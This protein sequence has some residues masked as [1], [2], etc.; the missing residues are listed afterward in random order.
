MRRK[1][2][3]AVAM[4]VAGGAA[5]LVWQRQVD[6]PSLDPGRRRIAEARVTGVEYGA[7]GGRGARGDQ[8]ASRS[9]HAELEER[10]RTAP[11]AKNLHRLAL[12]NFALLRPRAAEELLTRAVSL[13][14]GDAP[15]LSDLAAAEMELGQVADAAE[16]AARALELDPSYRPAAFNWALALDKFSNRP[17][18][19]EAWERY[20]ELDPA[21]PWAV[22]ARQHLQRLDGPRPE[23]ERDKLLL[24]AGS[25][26]D[27]VDRIARAYPQRTRE[28]ALNDLLP[29]FVDSGNA[30]ALAVLRK[31]AAIRTEAGDSFLHDAVEHAVANRESVAD[32]F[33]AFKEGD[34][35]DDANQMDKS[36]P[37]YRKAAESL[38]QAGSPV[39]LAAELYAASAETYAP[40]GGERAL[41]RLDALDQ[42]L[43]SGGSRYPWVKAEVAWIRGFIHV[44]AGRP[45]ECLA[46]YTA[47]LTEARRIGEIE[48]EASLLA[49]IATQLETVGDPFEAEQFRRDA[50]RRLD[51]SNA[52]SRRTYGA[53]LETGT[54]SLRAARPR[55]ALAFLDAAARIGHETRDPMY[56]ADADLWRALA[57]LDIG[58][59]DDA[60]L[61]IASARAQVPLIKDANLATRTS[62]NLE[63]I[64]ARIEAK[65][66]PAL[67]IQA[68]SGAVR[69]W[70]RFGW[71]THLAS[72]YVSR[73]EVYLALQD[74]G[75]AERDFR[76][77][78]EE[79]E[80][81]RETI[82]EPPMRVSY[83]ERADRVFD[84]LIELLLDDGRIEEAFTIAEK[85]RARAL[86]DRIASDGRAVPLGAREVA[87]RVDRRTSMIEFVLMERGAELWL[88]RDGRITHRR[89][90]A[91]GA[92][93]EAALASHLTA[94]EEDDLP[95]VRRHGRW[96]FDQLIAPLLP[97][98][99]AD[100]D[101]VLIPDGALQS[102]PF[103]TLVLPDQTFLIQRQPL[104]IA[105][106][107]SVFLRALPRAD[108]YAV[109]AVAQPAPGGYQALHR[110]AGEVTAM[111]REYAQSRVFVG[112][113]C[114]PSRFLEEAAEAGLLHFAGHAKLDVHTPARS[115]LV[116]ESANGDAELLSVERIANT[117]LN[118]NP[119]VVLAACSTGRGKLRRT[120]GL[121]SLASAFLQAGARG[122]VATLSDVNDDA[123]ARLFR[124]FHH[125][126]R[127]GARLA[128]ALRD[129]QLVQLQ[130][131]PNDN[132]P[133]VWGTAVVIGTF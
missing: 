74:R 78:I 38:R 9:A 111:K 11:T 65:R 96:L 17:K 16:H 31:I 58:R 115:A 129:A 15:M 76:A 124:T 54:N 6:N 12:A 63:F 132:R 123:S 3:G 39:A 109:V 107:A 131:N 33:R 130:A 32:G 103:A 104:A 43:V 47:A 56:V 70:Q 45:E 83:F 7:F 64:T 98:I 92:A 23:W 71:R 53:Y 128:D 73:G 105:P 79:F 36:L 24:L 20:L 117:R 85:K 113:E 26:P 81:R 108:L 86:L 60:T 55:L 22:E 44:R 18:A 82:K 102:L 118:R 77:A 21:S 114:S 90:S 126:L 8:N 87:A 13:S 125:N 106:S 52:S 25:W 59:L 100:S 101:L 10:V 121:D 99:P 68:F 72:A 48:N 62:G 19:R 67:A 41:V 42:S 14:N 122:V 40:G 88:V 127:R 27:E 116:F 93:I 57:L 30:S 37:E 4:F 112:P 69:T 1:I 5:V 133:S 46:A 84:R 50:L 89:S 94:V 120:E 119:V 75:A 51:E 80:R 61:A 110:A 91:S 2:A 29:A 97:G 35:H 28:T 34:R 95:N 49:M 66:Q